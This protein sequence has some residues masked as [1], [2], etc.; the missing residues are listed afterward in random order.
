MIYLISKLKDILNAKLSR[1]V[2]VYILAG[3]ATTLVNWI[4]YFVFKNFFAPTVSNVIAWAVS[5][6]FAY[7]VNS[8]FVFETRPDSLLTDIK[9]FCE[10]TAARAASGALESL[11]IFVFVE[12]LMINDLFV[13]VVV[14]VFVIVFNYIVSKLWIFSKKYKET[15]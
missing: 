14:S 5:V 11:S 10:F 6:V 8:R 3:I 15:K 4:V 1:E 13:K 9:L 7:A 2:I 12:K